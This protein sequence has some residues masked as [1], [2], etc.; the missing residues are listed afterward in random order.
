MGLSIPKAPYNLDNYTNATNIYDMT[1]AGNQ[2]IGGLLGVFI[3]SFVFLICFI[4][5]KRQNYDTKDCLIVSSM[6]S[7]FICILL[8]T[9]LQWVSPELIYYPLVLLLSS[10]ILK[11]FNP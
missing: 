6:I 8:I 10:I 2:I 7:T 1:E 5:L 3:V 11:I 9:P 4:G